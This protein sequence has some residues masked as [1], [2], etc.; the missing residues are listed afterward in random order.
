MS[1]YLMNARN[2][3]ESTGLS[4]FPLPRVQ[5]CSVGPPRAGR[6]FEWAIMQSIVRDDPWH[7]IDQLCI[8]ALTSARAFAAATW[9]GR[10]RARLSRPG[11]LNILTACEPMCL[12]SRCRLIL[13]ASYRTALTRERKNPSRIAREIIY[14]SAIYFREGT[15]SES[16]LSKYV[17]IS[18]LPWIDEY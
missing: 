14:C 1:R 15:L 17:D 2:R 8:H 16:S 11:S 18:L 5:C 3:A 13:L 9:C 12:S 4:R 7:H 6:V 10:P